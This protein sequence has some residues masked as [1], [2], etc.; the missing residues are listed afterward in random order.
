VAAGDGEMPAGPDL[1][2]LSHLVPA[3]QTLALAPPALIAPPSQA[4]EQWTARSDAQNRPLRVTLT[5]DPD[6]GRMLSREDF[7]Q[8]PVLDRIIAVGI[9]AHEGQLF[10][11][12]NQALGVFTATGLTVVAI[13]A[14]VMWWR[15]RPEGM[16]GAPPHRV[17]APF[18]AGLFVLIAA[19]AIT[20]P[21]FGATLLAVLLLEWLVL[22]RTPISEYPLPLVLAFSRIGLLVGIINPGPVGVDHLAESGVLVFI[23]VTHETLGRQNGVQNVV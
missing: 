10:A 1:H 14:I 13:S 19:L 12:L 3:V 20:L 21:L 6:S 2:T 11:P 8:Q 22:R 7:S 18:A 23:P 15:R 9:A 16:L 4:A 17:R 5:L